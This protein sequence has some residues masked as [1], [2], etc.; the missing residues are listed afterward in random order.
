[1][2]CP[3]SYWHG[4]AQWTSAIFCLD[5][6]A[7]RESPLMGGTMCVNEPVLLTGRRLP[8]GDGRDQDRPDGAGNGLRPDCECYREV[9]P[10]LP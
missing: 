8:G 10:R 1:M 4:L 5:A 3:M 9:T 2:H 7:P 6:C